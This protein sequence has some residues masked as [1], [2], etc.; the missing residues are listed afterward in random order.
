[1]E[2]DHLEDQGVDE[3]IILKWILEKWD[4]DHGLDRSGSR[5]GQVAGFCECGNEPWDSIECG[6]LLDKLRTC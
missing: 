4:G 1:M 3:K 5:K 6:E 2:G